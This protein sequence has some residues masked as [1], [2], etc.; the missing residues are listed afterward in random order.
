MTLSGVADMFGVGSILPFLTLA[1]DPN[2]DELN[3]V[4][5]LINDLVAAQS[6]QELTI[7]V[8]ILTFT[9]FVFAMV[10]KS[11]AI[12]TQIKFIWRLEFSISRRLLSNYLYRDFSELRLINSSDASKNILTEVRAII[13]GVISPLLIILSQSINITLLVLLLLYISSQATIFVIIVYAILYSSIY[14]LTSNYLKVLGEER[15]VKNT[16]RFKQIAEAFGSV[17]EVKLGKQ[18]RSFL[19]HFSLAARVF[20]DN[21]SKSQLIGI[22][23]RYF[24]ETTTFGLVLLLVIWVLM[25]GRSVQEVVPLLGLFALAGYRMLPAA[26]QIYNSLTQIRF[27]FPAMLEIRNSLISENLL[28]KEHSTSSRKVFKLKSINIKNLKFRHF[29]QKDFELSEISLNISRGSWVALVGPTGSGKTTF[30]DLISGLLLPTDGEVYYNNIKTSSNLFKDIQSSI[31][32]VPQDSFLFDDTVKNNIFPKD[33]CDDIE[34]GD[35]EKALYASCA[36]DFIE[37]LPRASESYVGERG[38]LL[39]GGQKQR[40]AIARSLIKKPS[41]LIL[42]EATSALDISTEKKVLDRIRSIY[43]NTTVIMIAHRIQAIKSCD[44]I[45]LIENGIIAGSGEY[46][47]LIKNSAQFRELVQNDEKLDQ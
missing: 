22:L 30:V 32:Y 18:E 15:V 4:Y 14:Y 7:Y 31:G 38:S 42:D 2:G 36:I 3:L 21:Q 13:N 19:R 8:G 9:T 12:Y 43:P 39:S 24:F 47:Y 29:T 6:R 26:Q 27:N 23:P 44:K 17:R 1:T 45:Y 16:E 5:G 34:N 20:A 40:I 10:V 41:I 33:S 28:K 35:F 25:D 46:K 11:F 37:N